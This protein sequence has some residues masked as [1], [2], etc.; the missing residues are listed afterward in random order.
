MRCRRTR[1]DGGYDPPRTQL[2][3]VGQR[4]QASQGCVKA[5]IASGG[6]LCWLSHQVTWEAFPNTEAQTPQVS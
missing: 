5:K 2:S 4:F 1:C 3:R 6:S